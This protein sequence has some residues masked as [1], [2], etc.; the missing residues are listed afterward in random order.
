LLSGLLFSDTNGD[1]NQEESNMCLHSR[2]GI[3]LNT[4]SAMKS[5]NRCA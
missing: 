5:R 4:L 2:E 1:E 3:F